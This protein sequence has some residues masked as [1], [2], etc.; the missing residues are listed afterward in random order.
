[1]FSGGDAA[2]LNAGP[3]LMFITLPKVFDAMPAGQII[4]SLFFV[5]VALAALTSSISLMETVTAVVMEKFNLSRMKSCI[6]V[7]FLTL[8]L[9][10]LSVLG[11]SAWDTVT[12]IGM[13]ILDFFDFITNNIMMPVLALLTCAM[14]GYVVKTK[15]IED[16]VMHGEKQFRSKLLYNVM[17]KYICPVCMILILLTPFIFKSL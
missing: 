2:A 12:I 15:Y 10:M 16:E 7:I 5:L 8:V 9:G 11:Y 3:G 13:Q 6:A 4:G 1:M 17:I 14:V